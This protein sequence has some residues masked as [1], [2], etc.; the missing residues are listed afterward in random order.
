MLMLIT[1]TPILFN[2]RDFF[3]IGVYNIEDDYFNSYSDGTAGFN[4]HLN[5]NL[6]ID[7]RFIINNFIE[8]ISTGYL[9][10]NGLL[11]INIL[12]LIDNEYAFGRSVQFD[13]PRST[14]SPYRFY[15]NLLKHENFTCYGTI[16]ISLETEGI[17]INDN[18]SFQLTFIV[19]LGRE[20]YMNIDLMIYVLL[21]IHFLFYII[22]PVILIWIF[23]PLLGFRYSKEDIKR[24]DKF[25][26]YIQNQGSEER[27]KSKD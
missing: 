22:I 20:D 25:F 17:P 9:V 12:Y 19:P 1:L 15:L 23:K 18:I 5:L 4:L 8:P 21:P 6:E 3:G 7:N 13:T 24:D 16:E 11:S 14:Y 27:K 26:N 10:N 2:F